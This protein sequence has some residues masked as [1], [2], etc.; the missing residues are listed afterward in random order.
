MNDKD[1]D[2]IVILAIHQYYQLKL[3]HEDAVHPHSRY[4][5]DFMRRLNAYKCRIRQ[6]Y[7]PCPSLHL[8]SMSTP[9]V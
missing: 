1:D 4:R 7:I 3:L 5:K 9:H 2:L 8:P 6:R